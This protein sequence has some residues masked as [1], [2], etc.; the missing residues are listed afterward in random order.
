MKE[1]QIEALLGRLFL[2]QGRLGYTNLVRSCLLS[3]LSGG[4]GPSGAL[5]G[6]GRHGYNGNMGTEQGASQGPQRTPSEPTGAIRAAVEYGIDVEM[7]RANLALTPAER[8]RRHQI[9]LNTVEMLR[10]AK[11]KEELKECGASSGG[12]FSLR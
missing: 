9:A 10:K 7:L 4:H 3:V 11:R 6:G 2:S 12:D 5:A 8:L 1:E